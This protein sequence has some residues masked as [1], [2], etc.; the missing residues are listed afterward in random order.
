MA[1]RDRLGEDARRRRA[2]ARAEG[3]RQESPRPGRQGPGRGLAADCAGRNIR[4]EIT[5][6]RPWLRPL[7][8]NHPDVR[9]YAVALY[10]EL[11]ASYGL[12]YVMSAIVS[13]DEGGPEH[14]G[15][16]CASCVRAA[17]EAGF[18]LQ[19]AQ[20]ALL[21]DPGAEPARSEWQNFREHSTARFYRAIHERIHALKPGIDL[22]TTST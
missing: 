21:A 16:F 1:K 13:F 8:P 2:P 14:G 22:D 17:A 11:V 10:S 15:C 3:R 5:H 9:N 12:D 6:V 20:K 4:G 7:C 19:R 18:D